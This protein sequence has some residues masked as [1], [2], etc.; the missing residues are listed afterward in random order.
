M[1][2]INQLLT[3]SALALSVVIPVSSFAQTAMDHSKMGM[4][5]PAAMTDGENKKLDVA[6]GK[7]TINLDDSG[8]VADARFHVTQFRGFEK[9]AQGRPFWEMPSLMARTCGICPVSHLVASAKACDE[10]LAPPRAPDFP[11]SGM[12]SVQS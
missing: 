8:E 12:A 2:K 9:F 5:H 3:I 11:C 7:I 6:N 1:N 10:L 4:S